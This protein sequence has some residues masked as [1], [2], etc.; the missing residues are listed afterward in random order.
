MRLQ[1]NYLNG[2]KC[3]FEYIGN[4]PTFCPSLSVHCAICSN[5]P[6]TPNLY[7]TTPLQMATADNTADD[8]IISFCIL[9][10]RG[11]SFAGSWANSP[12]LFLCGKDS[13]GIG[14]LRNL[15]NGSQ[16]SEHLYTRS[17]SFGAHCEEEDKRR[18]DMKMRSWIIKNFLNTHMRY[19]SVVLAIKTFR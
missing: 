10:K 5:I 1:S 8:I 7:K 14:S 16:P 11:I 13:F 15:H 2:E 6:E 4:R 19:I 17:L 9:R 12:P 3:Q 18:F